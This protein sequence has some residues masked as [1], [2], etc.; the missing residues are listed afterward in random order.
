[1]RKI[2][3][4]VQIFKS[5]ADE[6]RLRIL[7]ML[8]VRPLCVCELYVALD[9]ALSTLSAHLKILKNADLVEDN[10]DGRW[11]TYKLTEKKPFRDILIKALERYLEKDITFIND[12]TT[13][14]RLTREQ[15]ALKVRER[16]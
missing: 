13:I 16:V 3:N 9:I 6:S 2:K 8:R 1:M 15:C 11:V 4:Y 10:K 7:L 14:S 12:R 5:I